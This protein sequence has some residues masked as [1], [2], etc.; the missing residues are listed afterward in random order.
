MKKTMFK[1]DMSFKKLK[2]VNIRIKLRP[3]VHYSPRDVHRI[4]D[5]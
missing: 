5:K 2:N 4:A 3:F 1:N